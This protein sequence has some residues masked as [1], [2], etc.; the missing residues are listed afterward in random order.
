MERSELEPILREVEKHAILG[1]LHAGLDWTIGD[2]ITH[3]RNGGAR[4]EALTTLTIRELLEHGGPC[5]LEPVHP[6]HRLEQALRDFARD[7]D[8]STE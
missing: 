3:V 2:L 7:P 5:R 6:G 8:E 4:A 1:V